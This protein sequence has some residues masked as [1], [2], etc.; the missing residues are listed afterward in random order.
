MPVLAI[1]DALVR[2]I[3]HLAKLELTD[4]EVRAFA[5]QLAEILTYVRGLEAVE[6]S[7]VEPLTHPLGGVMPLR[8]DRRRDA[9]GERAVQE[10]ILA[11]APDTVDGGFKV[12]PIL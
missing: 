8:E 1:D 4:E 10:K 5:P 12:P 2:K 6:V 9:T 11:A 3:A 7:K